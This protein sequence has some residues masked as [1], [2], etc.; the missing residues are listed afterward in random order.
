MQLKK[1]IE[2]NFSGLPT[3]KLR[4]INLM[5]LEDGTVKIDQLNLCGVVLF[6][7]QAF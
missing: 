5:Y 3:T 6:T 4:Y 7:C 1:N 2:I